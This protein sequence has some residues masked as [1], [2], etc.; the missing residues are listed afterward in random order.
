MDILFKK[1]KKKHNPSRLLSQCFKN[2][3]AGTS[4]AQL[5]EQATVNPV[6]FYIS[7]HTFMEVDTLNNKFFTRQFNHS[8][9]GAVTL[10]A[11]LHPFRYFNSGS[12]PLECDKE[13]WDLRDS[14]VQCE[15][16]ILRQ[17]NF[18]VSFEHPHKVVVSARARIPVPSL[19]G[20][21]PPFWSVLL[22]D[23]LMQMCLC[24]WSLWS[25]G[26]ISVFCWLECF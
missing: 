21:K 19:F 9:F 10:N 5:D 24:L 13:F 22:P 18:Q 8:V 25:L 16:L 23:F 14:V 6:L 4:L 17:L 3:W 15:L 1:K 11:L 20:A 2:M 7:H 26:Q 12:T